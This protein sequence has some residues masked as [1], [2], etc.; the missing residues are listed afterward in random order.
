MAR[1]VLHRARKERLRRDRVRRAA[2]SVAACFCVVVLAALVTAE[3]WS[4][5]QEPPVLS[6]A[7]EGQSRLSVFSVNAAEY[8]TMIKN[9]EVQ[10]G[11][12]HVRDVK[13]YTELERVFIRR[14]EMELVEEFTK[15][16]WRASQTRRENDNTIFV[17]GLAEVL[18]VVPEDIEQVAEYSARSECGETVMT[19][20]NPNKDKDT[21]E[22]YR[23]IDVWWQPPEEQVNK[24]LN[25]P[26]TK[27]STVKD[28]ITVTVKFTDG[29]T[30]SVIIDVTVDDEG[31]IYMSHRGAK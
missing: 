21:G 20:I 30:E 8:K 3:L 31:L 29:S 14:E 28:T 7:G 10:L 26:D 19:A 1:V 22:F 16:S 23:G 9:V 27:L 13:G 24:L 11:L 18:I 5:V 2:V 15:G 4:P 12:M 17:M 6:T 25:D